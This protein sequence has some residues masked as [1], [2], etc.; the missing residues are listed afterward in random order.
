MRVNGYKIKAEADL[1]GANLAGANFWHQGFTDTRP[2][3]ASLW[4]ANLCD[5]NLSNTNL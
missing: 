4:R 2:R 3:G 1:A 5:A